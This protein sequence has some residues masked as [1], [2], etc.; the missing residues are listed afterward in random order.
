MWVT[1]LH[2]TTDPIGSTYA[3]VVY[4]ESAR[5]YFIYSDLNLV[6]VFASYIP[7]EYLKAPSSQKEYNIRGPEFG[8]EN[9]GKAALIHISLYG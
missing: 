1:D 6:G 7:N 3:G 5:I 2:K 4:R 8:L 9:L